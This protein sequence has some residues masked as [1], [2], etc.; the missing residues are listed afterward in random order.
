M[1]KEPPD[2]VLNAVARLVSLERREWIGSPSEP[3]TMIMPRKFIRGWSKSRMRWC[4]MN[5]MQNIRL[6]LPQKDGSRLGRHLAHV[7]SE[8]Y[9]VSRQPSGNRGGTIYSKGSERRHR[10]GVPF[11]SVRRT[12]GHRKNSVFR[13][14]LGALPS[15]SR[16]QEM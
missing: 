11:E 4:G 16:Q 7:S 8:D 3:I 12:R 15:T 1:Y 13:K 9:C 14:G 5:C 2:P 6:R 10:F